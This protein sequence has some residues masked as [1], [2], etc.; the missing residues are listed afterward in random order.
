MEILS[1]FNTLVFRVLIPLRQKKPTNVTGGE[2]PTN[3]NQGIQKMQYTK[4]HFT[5][6]SSNL[7]T[8]NISK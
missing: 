2:D 6:P 3:Q 8:I 1:I 5:I 7:K 4:V